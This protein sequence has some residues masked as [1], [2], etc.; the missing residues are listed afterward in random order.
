MDWAFHC[1]CPPEIICHVCVAQCCP[2]PYSSDRRP[3][4]GKQEIYV[5]AGDQLAQ[6]DGI[7]GEATGA[8]TIWVT[9]EKALENMFD[10]AGPANV[11]QSPTVFGT[12]DSRCCCCEW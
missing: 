4:I 12:C 9:L 2:C 5:A 6:V 8:T 7:A 10:Q 3:V 11:I 1:C